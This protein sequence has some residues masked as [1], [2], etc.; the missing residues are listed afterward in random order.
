MKLEANENGEI[1]LKEV[2]SGVG[3]QTTE[4]DTFG[5]CMRDFGFEFNYGGKRYKAE[6]GEVSCMSQPTESE[7]P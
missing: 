6:Y 7:T 4:G 5:I 1:I 2:F 3:L